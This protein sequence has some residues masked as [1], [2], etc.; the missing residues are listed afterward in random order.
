[1]AI[2]YIVGSKGLY[3]PFQPIFDIGAECIRFND[4]IGYNDF[5]AEF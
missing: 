4:L 5:A 3:F 2:R 1:M